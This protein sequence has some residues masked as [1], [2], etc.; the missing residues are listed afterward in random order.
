LYIFTG[1]CCPGA[2]GTL[3][4]VTREMES[5]ENAALETRPPKTRS[6]NQSAIA[7]GHKNGIHYWDSSFLVE[8][9]NLWSCTVHQPNSH[10]ELQAG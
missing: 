7:C 3:C 6:F 10:F 5:G 8:L 2:L 1:G 9:M 4:I